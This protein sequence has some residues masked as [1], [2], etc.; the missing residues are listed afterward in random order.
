M[1]VKYDARLYGPRKP[2]QKVG[3][4]GCPALWFSPPACGVAGG[5]TR[6]KC[7]SELCQ[8]QFWAAAGPS[9]AC[10]LPGCTVPG[11]EAM[12]SLLPP[13]ACRSLSPS[14]SSRST[15]LLPS[16]ASRELWVAAISITLIQSLLHTQPVSRG[17]VARSERRASELWLGCATPLSRCFQA[18][19]LDFPRPASFLPCSAPELT[20]EASEAIAEYYADLRNSQEV[21]ALP[22]TVSQA[23][24]MNQ[25]VATSW[26]ATSWLAGWP[27]GGVA[28]AEYGWLRMFALSDRRFSRSS[29]APHLLRSA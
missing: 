5:P 29:P 9:A 17:G 14:R 21:K 1:Y 16:S 15:S 7:A 4:T 2:G 25:E 8:L 3:G 19:I 26:L 18:C 23:S 6:K 20:A 28:V 22:V 10:A 24:V 27:T 13:T 11:W 12:K